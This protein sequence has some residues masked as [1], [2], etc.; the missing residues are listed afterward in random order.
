[1]KKKKKKPLELLDIKKYLE[2]LFTEYLYQ[3]LKNIRP[4]E[5]SK[6]LLD[7]FAHM[8]YEV[9]KIHGTGGTKSKGHKRFL[10]HK[11]V[12]LEIFNL[13]EGKYWSAILELK[14]YKTI[15][16][17]KASRDRKKNNTQ[18]SGHSK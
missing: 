6:I 8:F 12:I 5:I 10:N 11:L 13:L 15:S 4:P 7:R 18:R 9:E 14:N 17:Q 1:M 16:D 3:K 2:Y